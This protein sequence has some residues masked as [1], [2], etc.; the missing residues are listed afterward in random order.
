[1][2]LL[3][4]KQESGG[5]FFSTAHFFSNTLLVGHHSLYFPAEQS[6]L[7]RPTL[8]GALKKPM[9]H[10]SG[11]AAAC[12]FTAGNAELIR[13]SLYSVPKRRHH[14]ATP[15]YEH[16][17][18]SNISPSRRVFTFTWSKSRLLRFTAAAPARSEGTNGPLLQLFHSPQADRRI[19]AHNHATSTPIGYW[20]YHSN[21]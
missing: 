17:R 18:W 20:S 11:H 21:N 14:S 10:L 6:Q 13:P 19:A 15:P 16:A 4:E 12:P 8:Q 3:Q 9:R 7:T 1:M 5:K 2:G